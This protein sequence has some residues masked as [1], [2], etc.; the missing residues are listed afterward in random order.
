MDTVL[1]GF[2]GLGIA[3]SVVVFIT[4]P[5]AIQEIGGAILWCGG[6]V[7]VGLGCII[8]RMDNAIDNLP[9]KPPGG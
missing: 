8:A 3:A 1:K 5:S 2:G 6:W 4:A 9:R 7:M